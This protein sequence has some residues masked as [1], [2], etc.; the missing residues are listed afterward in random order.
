[1][2]QTQDHMNVYSNGQKKNRRQKL[3]EKGD[4][5]DKHLIKVNVNSRNAKNNV[6]INSA[7]MQ[8]F[9]F[10]SKF[11]K[12][13]KFTMRNDKMQNLKYY[14]PRPSKHNKIFEINDIVSI[15]GINN[16]LQTTASHN[17][18]YNK[19]ES[20]NKIIITRPPNERIKSTKNTIE[21]Q[22]RTKSEN[23][24]SNNVRSEISNYDLYN[25]QN[26]NYDINNGWIRPSDS[27]SPEKK[28]KSIPLLQPPLLTN[29][30]NS[31]I[32]KK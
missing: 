4:S 7:G 6:A 19:S 14:G 13:L 15:V 26:S 10:K 21:D 5:P 9:N 8:N 2:N 27:V 31:T 25:S 32:I 22:K 12:R 23:R 11:K 16:R 28:L 17:P 30:H 24:G 3:L 1:M 29:Q 18:R 20:P